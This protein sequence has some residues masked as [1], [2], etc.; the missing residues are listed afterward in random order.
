[1]SKFLVLLALLLLAAVVVATANAA[2]LPDARVLRMKKKKSTS[3][4]KSSSK[5]GKS[6]SATGAEN[7]AEIATLL[8]TSCMTLGGAPFTFDKREC[9]EMTLMGIGVVMFDSRLN[10]CL[11]CCCDPSFLDMA[12]ILMNCP[13]ETDSVSGPHCVDCWEQDNVE[14][15]AA[16]QRASKHCCCAAQQVLMMPKRS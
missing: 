9:C 3:S 4:G 6:S 8:Q 1:M 10:L 12:A 2:S 13:A 11:D 16:V 5:G 14:R 7:H 15:G